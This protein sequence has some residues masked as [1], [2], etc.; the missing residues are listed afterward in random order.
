MKLKFIVL[1]AAIVVSFNTTGESTTR[2]NLLVPAY[3][4]PAGTGL[5]D[6]NRL[7]SASSLVSL[8][9]I[10]NPGNGPGTI[11]DPNYVA[12]VSNVR[13]AGGSVAG[14]V[15]TSYA[16][17][18]LATV[19]AD[20]ASY[21]SFNYN[22]NGIFVDEMA[23][24]PTAANLGYYASLYA[25]IKTTHPDWH[26]FGNAGTSTD[27][28]FLTGP[29]GRT[30]DT[31]MVFENAQ[32]AYPGY[33][34]DAWNAGFARNNFGHIIHTT[35]DAPTM[36]ADLDRAISLN[37]GYAFVT[38]DILPN[39]YD[40]LP[41]YWPAEVGKVQSTPVPEPVGFLGIGALTIVLCATGRRTKK[42]LP[43]TNPSSQ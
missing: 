33:T 39:P 13:N 6:W 22:I 8:T 16:A 40:T 43:C 29:N 25:Y 5:T 42:P 27:P 4:Y 15:Y 11:A 9:A 7:T 23:N 28:A 20:I 37:A 38:D 31:L 2:L 34:P 12:A 35:A 30:A 14:Y 18:S 21:A 17:R 19:E 32:A 36:S 24:A 10:M 1:V 3:F 26:V 41:A